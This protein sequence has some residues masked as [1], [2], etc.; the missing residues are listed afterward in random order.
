ML[1]TLSYYLNL[2]C[3]YLV[4]IAGMKND[5]AITA[6]TV[7]LIVSFV[8]SLGFYVIKSIAICTIAKK[9]GL[10]KW[11]WGMIPYFNYALLG[12]ISGPVSIFGLKIK[13]PGVLNASLL[14]ATHLILAVSTLAQCLY[15]Y[16][17]RTAFIAYFYQITTLLSSA[18]SG[19]L[20]L[21]QAI[22]FVM[23]CLGLFSKYAPDRVMLFTLLSIFI[24]PAFS[25][26][27][28]IIRNRK[29]YASR[30]DYYKQKMA[31]RYGQTYDPFSN[32]YETKENPF[33]NEKD[34]KSDNPFE[35]Y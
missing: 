18:T 13:N 17:A 28:M 1:E 8:I 27:L 31:N 6:I 24:N 29:P 23:L 3:D 12:S 26:I 30:E 20:T 22:A 4:K 5:E 35:G 34:D 2:M 16:G 32:P 10:K 9:Q 7:S 11:W 33:V 14:F 25:I 15:Y 21:I 19:I